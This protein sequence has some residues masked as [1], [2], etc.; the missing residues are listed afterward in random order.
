MD[1]SG[2]LSTLVTALADAVAARLATRRAD[3]ELL[4]IRTAAAESGTGQ[5]RLRSAVAAGRLA[6]YKP[7]RKIM[8]RRGDV[9]DYVLSSPRRPRAVPVDS[10]AVDR[11]LGA[12]GL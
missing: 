1:D 3:D 11:L 12:S 2:P 5:D 4:D 6:G 7:G 8:V 9:R 10:D